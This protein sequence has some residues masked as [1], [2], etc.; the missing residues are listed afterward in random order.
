MTEEILDEK[1]GIEEV[2]KL[3][4]MVESTMIID[5][6]CVPIEGKCVIRGFKVN[7][8]TLNVSEEADLRGIVYKLNNFGRKGS[9]DI[10]GYTDSDGS[11]KY[12]LKLS[13]KRAKNV[14]KLLRVYGLSERFIFGKIIGKGESK[15]VDTNDTIEGRYNNRR[16]EIFFENMEFERP[17]FLKEEEIEKLKERGILK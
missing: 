9:I 15:P 3:N 7:G 14:A 6:F 12:N 2:K 8:E 5:D 13:L 16:V 4:C 17:R 11:E 10:V 1:K